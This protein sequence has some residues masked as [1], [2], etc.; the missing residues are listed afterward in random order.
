MSDLLALYA[1][2]KHAIMQHPLSVEQISEFRRQLTELALPR[3]AALEQ[4][5]AALIDENLTFPR[6]QIFYV[7][8]INSDGSL[9]SFPIHPFHWQAM[10]APERDSFV[11]NAFIYQGT[12]V[13][14]TTATELIK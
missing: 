12:A 5:I 13:D 2:T 14:M 7:Q 6:F 3:E 9:F 8:N 10:S 4:A 1:A 11:T